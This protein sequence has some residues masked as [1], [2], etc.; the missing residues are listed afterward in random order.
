MGRPTYKELELR[1]SKLEKIESKYND[2]IRN[3]L[4]EETDLYKIFRKNPIGMSI[5]RLKDSMMLDV[6]DAILKESGYSRDE[7]IGKTLDDLQS[8]VNDNDKKIFYERL[9]KDG[10]IDKFETLIQFNLGMICHCQIS[11]LL[12]NYNGE[13]C[14][15]TTLLDITPQKEAEINSR[16]NLEKYERLVENSPDILHIYSNKRG[17]IFW[18]SRVEELL[19]F[20][21]N[22]IDKNPRIWHDSIHEED[23]RKI[24]EAYSDIDSLK[25]SEFV[26]RIKDTNGHWHWLRDKIINIYDSEGEVIVEAIASD[27]TREREAEEALQKMNRDLESKVTKRTEE[28]SAANRA[29]RKQVNQHIK[30][31]NDLREAN[32]FINTLIESANVMVIGLDRSGNVSLYNEAARKI[33][34]YSKKELEKINWFERIVPKEKYKKVWRVFD[35]YIH[36]GRLPKVFENPILTKSG[37]EKYISWRN[38]KI[39]RP[40]MNLSTFSFGI[41]ITDRKLIEDALHRSEER[42]KLAVSKIPGLVWIVDKDLRITMSQGILLRKFGLHPDQT[43]GM[44][45]MEYFGKTDENYVPFLM[46]KQTFSGKETTY[47]HKFNNMWLD[48]N[49]QPVFDGEKNV[50][51]VFGVAF[52]VTEKVKAEKALKSSELKYKKLIKNMLNGYALHKIILNN[53][54]E[55]VDYVFLEINDAFERLTGLKRKDIIGKRVT[56]VLPGIENAEFD[57]I[58]IYG[59][60]AVSKLEVE[61]DQYSKE[62]NRW[63]SITVQSPRKYYFATIFEDIT[64]RKKAEEALKESENRYREL[65]ER[66]SELFYILDDKG[67]VTFVNQASIKI[68]G[69]KPEEMIGRPYTDF[70]YHEDLEQVISDYN[71]IVSGKNLIHEFRLKHITKG[72]SQVQ[73]ISAPRFE[74]NRIIGA[75]GLILDITERKKAEEKIVESE[76]RFRTMADFTFDWEYWRGTDGNLVYISPS[77]ERITGYS[78]DELTRNPEILD[79]IVHTEDKEKVVDHRRLGGTDAAQLDYRIITKDGETKWIN[80]VCQPVYNSEG[81]W[82][83]NRASNRDITERKIAED[84]VIKSRK[85]L[86]KLSDHLQ[87]IRENERTHIAREIHDELGQSLTALKID[88]SML[89]SSDHLSKADP[90]VFVKL[91]SMISLVNDTIASVQRISA[92]LRPRMLDVLGLTAATE[93]ELE[94]FRKRTGIAFTFQS[95]IDDLNYDLSYSTTLFRIIQESL[96]NIA[97]HSKADKID[98][99]VR[100]ARDRIFLE[101]SDNGKGITDKEANSLNSL[102]LIGMR[103]RA[104]STGGAVLIKGDKG[105]GTTVTFFGPLKRSKK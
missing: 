11:S 85:E 51:H 9:K 1:I 31:E 99:V 54:N 100:E 65:V 82:L 56:E 50:S 52:D 39:D 38:V 29:L 61:F 32:D 72:Y 34:G 98:I 45:L 40:D 96:T 15:I 37:M 101:I 63:Y 87:T 95:E 73:S 44:T 2:L 71:T 48:I 67:I 97:R 93:H 102:G 26:Y 23:I 36:G 80:H 53:N 77:C 84:S 42:F 66:I 62:L 17:G 83:G 8:W 60:T 69:M 86:L 49:L 90:D 59:K 105:K 74:N 14:F 30:A 21:P 3:P 89:K 78:S 58:N 4:Y 79:T 57:W 27:I 76:E 81:E 7:V 5:I 22:E 25:N 12:I 64:D 43:K 28:L 103:E 47:T 24:D 75:Q 6:N 35:K 55:P 70:I 13:Q 94:Q 88:I 18:S 91:E 20:E 92:E 19:G 68:L 16:I 41:D 46:H 10:R 33:T 104:I